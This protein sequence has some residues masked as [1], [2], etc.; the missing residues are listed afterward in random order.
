MIFVTVGTQY[1]FD[2][3]IKTIDEWAGGRPHLN[4]FAQ[5]GSGKYQPKH[6]EFR[7]FIDPIEFKIRLQSSDCIF[8]HAGMG[9]ILLALE[10]GKPIIVMPRDPELG[11]HQNSHQIATAER[12]KE[13]GQ[14]QVAM[15]ENELTPLLDAYADT[16]GR[17]AISKEASEGLIKAIRD[18]IRELGSDSN[19]D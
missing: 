4:L 18:S 17:E 1:G 13:T 7:D 19:P 16:P 5:I 10:N 14:I 8:A 15:D 12:F 3:L 6:M 2:R 9:S 11:E